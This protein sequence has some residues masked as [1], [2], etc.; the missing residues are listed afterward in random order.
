MASS[1]DTGLATAVA[2]F[3]DAVLAAVY[4]GPAL[5]ANPGPMRG[6]K[7]GRH[8]DGAPVDTGHAAVD[9]R[10]ALVATPGSRRRR[11]RH[12]ECPPPAAAVAP[13]PGPAP[14]DA[15]E[16]R[17]DANEGPEARRRVRYYGKSAEWKRKKRKEAKMQFNR[18]ARLRRL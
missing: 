6:R 10:P 15:D 2:N 9:T 17:E 14:A 12:Q 4:T 11:G 16:G 5:V 18:N 8:L 13:I 1:H 7:R 3:R